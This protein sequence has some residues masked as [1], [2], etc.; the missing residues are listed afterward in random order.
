MKL[1]IADR[2]ETERTG[3]KWL[4]NSY[5]LGFSHVHE[6]ADIDTLIQLIESQVPEVL[7]VELEMIPVSS[8]ETF[9]RTVHRYVQTVI[10]M[11][12]ES[13]FERAMQAIQL[14][15]VN[16]LLKPLSP[17]QLK[18]S[19]GRIVQKRSRMEPLH[20]KNGQRFQ[21]DD[22][23]SLYKALFLDKTTPFPIHLMYVQQEVVTKTASLSQW[24]TNHPF[25]YEASILPLSDGV[26][27]LF[28]ANV[29][30]AAHYL[31][32]EAQRLL[33]EWEE[34]GQGRITVGVHLGTKSSA[35]TLHQAYAL[36]KKALSMQFFRGHQ[37]LLW[38]HQLP[39]Y[40]PLDPFLTPEEQRT[41]GTMLEQADKAKIK[42]WMYRQFTE[43]PQGY[44]E[45]DLL[46][47]RLTSVL[48][49]LRR[50]MQTYHLDRQSA[51][52]ARY[53]DV[54]QT[55]LYS[56]V[57]FRI[58]QEMVLFTFELIGAA[59]AQ[60]QHAQSDFI[61]RGLQYIDRHFTDPN[62]SLEEVANFVGRSPGY[63]SQLLSNRR[64]QTFRQYITE[65][66][67]RKA[68]NLLLSD[69]QTVQEIAYAV[70][71]TDANYFSRVFKTCTGLS[72][73]A[74]RNMMKVKET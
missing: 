3:I 11:T 4:V 36:T 57:L 45:P 70:G 44:P 7:C 61:E 43:F 62:L 39:T 73:R 67:I 66:R 25:L 37:Q 46:R 40:L 6:A 26:V 35:K 52:E 12:T 16:L 10:A 28:P 30:D 34:R 27:V 9:V 42:T 13:V 24:L 69:E 50:Y 41:W 14:H 21:Q 31:Q 63:F 33:Q 23:A 56:P 17:D 60:K 49:H 20:R 68:E 72:P 5:R 59:E 1:L 8:W 71:Y 2:D 47:I 32:T 64:Q 15:T 58:V 29:T 48:A 22:A 53:H 74:W 18:Q 38:V 54:F 19:L 51:L 65:K 55:I